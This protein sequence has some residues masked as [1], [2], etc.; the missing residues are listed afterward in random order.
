MPT[1]IGTVAQLPGMHSVPLHLL[2]V[3]IYPS[4]VQTTSVHLPRSAEAGRR[5][6]CSCGALSEPECF[7]ANC[8]WEAAGRDESLLIRSR[9]PQAGMGGG[10]SPRPVSESAPGICGLSWWPVDPSYRRRGLYYVCNHSPREMKQASSESPL[11]MT[12]INNGLRS[13][14]YSS[15]AYFTAGLAGN[16]WRPCEG[17][18]GCGPEKRGADLSPRP[19]LAVTASAA[20]SERPDVAGCASYSNSAESQRNPPCLSSSPLLCSPPSTC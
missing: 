11:S 9:P 6:F 13:C 4:R 19:S 12:P 7:P 10:W 3:Q 16:L 20:L 1:G 14:W 17:S 15:S 8:L 5:L 2:R 18:I